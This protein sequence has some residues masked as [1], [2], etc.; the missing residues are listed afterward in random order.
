MRR[1]VR[2]YMSL[3]RPLVLVLS[4]FAVLFAAQAQTPRVY[5]K[6][7]SNLTD[8]SN[9][10]VITSVTPNAG[11]TPTYAAD[12]NNTA[13]NAVDISAG[14]RSLQLVAA[15]L[16]GNSNQALGLRNASGTNTSFTLSAWIYCTNVSGGYNTV[17]GNTG[18]GAGTLH[19]G[20]G[21]NVDKAHFGFDGN[22]VTGAT[23]AISGSTWYHVAYI[24]DA[25]AQTQRIFVNGVPEVSRA[26]VT[27]TLKAADLL[28]GN[29]GTTTDG[30]NDFKGR[31]DDVA[32]WNVALSGDQIHAL[33][34]NVDPMSL[35]APGT[36]SAPKLAAN[37]GAAGTWGVREY[38]TSTT[39]PN[40]TN[41]I[42][43]ISIGTLVNADRILRSVTTTPAPVQFDYQ[44]ATINIVDDTGGGN[45]GYFTSGQTAWGTSAAGVDDNYILLVAKCA[46]RIN[47]ENDYTFGFRGD[48][49]SRLRVIG[50]QFISSTRLATGNPAD[51]AHSGDSLYYTAGV[52]D[53]NTL[54]V[55]HLKPGDY[56]LEFTY[57]EGSGGSSVEVYAAPGARTAVDTTNF[58][59][60]GDVS[61]GGLQIVPDPDGITLTAN[62]GSSTFVHNG[63]PSTITLAWGSALTPTSMS[64]NQGIGNVA[65]NGSTTIAAPATTTTYTL[66]ATYGTVTVTRAV[67][68]Y[69]NTAPQVTFSANRTLSTPGAAVNLSWTVNGATSLTLDPGGINVLGQSGQV[70]TPSATTTYTLT[71]S[72]PS[73]STQKQVTV[74][75]GAGPTINFFTVSD[76]APLFG[77]DTTLQWST[78]SA[79]SVSINQGVGTVA[80]TGSL[81]VQVYQT[82]TYTLT[83]TNS[84]GSSTASVLV[85][86][87]SPIGVSAAGF[88]VTRYNASTPLPFAGMGYL[89]SADAL[90]AGTNLSAQ[91]TVNGITS[92]NYSDGATGEFGGDSAFPSVS[93][94]STANNVNFAMKITGTLVVNTPG[95]YTFVVNCDDGARMRIDGV[96]VI[97][98]DAT[99]AVASNAGR[100]TIT[101][102]T[103]SFE[104]VYFNAPSNGG[105]AAA[106]LELAWIRPN[107]Q[108]QLLNTATPAT[109]VVRGQV[110]ISEFA[111]ENKSTLL[112]EDG[113]SSDWIEIWNSTNATVNLSSYFL[114][115]D[116]AVPN[117]WALPA[118]TLGTNQYLVVFASMLD[119]RP[120]QAVPGQ[121]NP[122]TIAQ[123]R[124]HTSFKLPKTGGYLAL[125]RS[126]GAG[127]YD[128]LSAFNYGPQRE[129]VSY[130]STDA[131]AYLGFME[132]PTPGYTNAVVFTD[133]VQDTV[134]SHQRG[135]YSAPF[136]LTISTPT[137]GATIRYTTDGSVPTLTRGYTYTAPIPISVTTVIRAAAFK[138]GWRPTNVDT[139]SYLFINDIVSQTAATATALG[140]PSGPVNSQVFR[141]GMTL[142]NVTAGGGTLQS[143]KDA[144]AGAP[145]VCM[146]TDIS[147]LTDINYG[148][149]VRP[150]KH[151]LFW[152]RPCS[153]EYINSA[154]ASEFQINCGVRVRGGASRSPSN[155]KH[156]FHLYFRGSLYDGRLNYRLFGTE[157]ASEFAQVDMRCEQNYSWSK[158]S[159][160]QNSLMRE[161]WSRLTQRD[162]GQPYARNGYFHLYI[163]GIYW[164][165]YNWEERTEADF[166]ETYLGGNKDNYDVV[167]SA[168]STGGYNTEMTDG[169]FIAWK[170]LNDQAI[171]LKNDVTSET[172]RTARYMQMQGLNAN[173]TRN[174]SYPV[175]LDVDNLIDYLLVVFYDGSFDSPMSTF[176]S[177][178][179]NN[180]FGA[181]DR[182]GNRGFAYFAHDHEHGMDSTGT[183][184][185]NRIGPWGGSGTNNWGQ[186]QYGTRETFAKSNPQYLHE[187][188]CYSAEYRQRFADRVHKHFFNAGAL[189]T[190]KSLA[191]VNAMVAQIDPIIHAEAARWGS[192]SLHRGTWFNTARQTVLNFINSGGSVPSGHPALTPGDRTSILLQQ[193]KGYT[194][195]SAKPLYPQSFQAPTFSGQF[196]GIVANGYTFTI[197]NPNGSGVIYYS[198][199]GEDPRLPGGTINPNALTGTSPISV[200]LTQTGT[201]KARVF[202]SGTLTWSAL[203]EAEFIVGIPAGASN[204]TISQ[205]HYNPESATDLD[206]FIE[207]MNVG[208]TSIDLTNTKFVL[209][210]QFQFPDGFV[211]APGARA[212]VIRDL[213]AFTAAYP[214]VP[215][216]K[217]AGVFENSTVLDNAGERIQLVDNTN[218]VIK[219]FSYGE[220]FPWPK[221]PDG[222][223]PSLVLK[224][225][226]ATVDLANATNWRPSYDV[227]GS[228]GASDSL[229][230]ATWAANNNIADPAADDD[231]DGLNNFG[232]Y[233]LG[234]NPANSLSGS[235][236]IAAKTP[237]TVN[238]V[239]N[240]YLTLTYTR[241]I[242]RDDV[243]Y[244]VEGT[245]ILGTSWAPAIQ[246]DD[247]I[248]NGD[249]TETL[250]YRYPTPITAAAQFLRLRM[251][252]IP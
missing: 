245:A 163:N 38:R 122:G 162:M 206:E 200:T 143:L 90:I 49:G 72:N 20:L 118:W 205:I 185:Y 226:S 113:A 203:V 128:T 16:S 184:S 107:L 220:D 209:G 188:L 145:A 194:D 176:L 153:V 154:G 52:G 134:F 69:V 14:S 88:T 55:V 121:D 168:G 37:P 160:A 172:S 155:P 158:D 159:N 227:G 224:R 123:P 181:R 240:T 81:E 207:V 193:L 230:Y 68:V 146:N 46:V 229:P 221:S 3:S 116:A 215:A 246:V 9:A 223:G 99:H 171:A 23:A 35:P 84:F 189:T 233:G 142:S 77:A 21:S 47:S 100:V 156:A 80:T 197:S 41:S 39:T 86:M 63:S 166:G 75:V 106:G 83:A 62:G 13:G 157:G 61:G 219:D 6:F 183:N 235:L 237:V 228:P 18:S 241:P 250:T 19:A 248:F 149:Y 236:P 218:A 133:F 12:R 164:G 57:W 208:A 44:A 147:N 140:F 2:H 65:Q 87:P 24:Y 111:A 34:N 17:F 51:P 89:Q 31:L 58:K 175:L 103:V 70:V 73:G 231:G 238:G 141:Y 117:K 252:Q 131:E 177:N 211:L 249:G 170:S 8:S 108:W 5:L 48:D 127:G 151:G 173:G 216:A 198:K 22:D 110:L 148:I 179:S 202:D 104:L 76:A 64:I 11:W 1:F 71:A 169:N 139:K 187:L 92:I 26:S 82:T 191:R 239:T 174:L 67:T 135:R 247:A 50:Q 201:V 27:N 210:I 85:N 150:D 32:V 182:A 130:G 79:T 36:Y 137:A 115:D 124:M 180:W 97:V 251:V 196:G 138:T 225:P 91:A 60:I 120:A 132:T 204:L 40:T 192:G 190:T 56:N 112:D 7:N 25:D 114:T 42:N 94:S 54:G 234:G 126:N 136:N 125:M 161:E 33:Y 93:G 244:N 10:G 30:S 74:T 213:T 144:L 119:R 59:L 96:D 101:K 78:G 66:T 152:E 28:I 212:V 105:S 43:G 165:V 232:E 195:V 109:P 214:S 217:I 45:A 129:D 222:D 178:A 98:D 29:W 95:E 199:T 102:P 53:S 243:N 4:F 167:K 15:S 242:G 186:G